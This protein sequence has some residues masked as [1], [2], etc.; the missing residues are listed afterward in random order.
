MRFSR[1]TRRRVGGAPLALRQWQRHRCLSMMG[2]ASDSARVAALL[3]KGR[4]EGWLMN[5]YGGVGV[6]SVDAA[7]WI[8][9]EMVRSPGK[10]GD[11]IGWKVGMDGADS[12]MFPGEDNPPGCRY[13]SPLFSAA[14]V[15]SGSTVTHARGGMRGV[16]V[17]IGFVLGESDTLYTNLDSNITR[18]H[19]CTRSSRI[20]L[21]G[22]ALPSRSLQAAPY[23]D[24]EVWSAM[25]TVELALEVCASRFTC[26]VPL[27]VVAADF[28]NH[29][30][31]VRGTPVPKNQVP[32]LQ[33]SNKAEQETTGWNCQ[34]AG[35]CVSAS[36]PTDN[37][38]IPAQE[39]LVES[40]AVSHDPRQSL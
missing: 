4:V 15:A 30:A 39:V 21:A 6:R 29:H 24:D 12:A 14:T 13:C 25:S 11:H 26:A 22:S 20:A 34:A 8:H 33:P 23:T 1:C 19:R 36:S 18:L 2:D 5:R 7:A 38:K 10:L 35:I 28:G 31:L 3:T 37:G 40:P 32:S 17:E 27:A 16:E 9:D